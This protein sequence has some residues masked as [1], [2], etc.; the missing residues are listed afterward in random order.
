MKRRA[1]IALVGGVAAAWPFAAQG[2]RAG[3]RR[4]GVL[5][6]VN[7]E[8]A[9]PWVAGV[10]AALQ[11]LGWA[12]GSTLQ[13]DFRFGGG[14]S[15]QVRR[16][17]DELLGMKPDVILTQGVV[18]AAALQQT[19]TSTPVVFAQVQDPI[20][21]GFVT[22]LSRP[23]GNLTGFTD[24]EYSIAG[25]WLQLLHEAAPDA[26][27]V[28]VVINPD[29]RARWDGYFKVI[30]ALAPS[31]GILP[32]RAGVH[33][34]AEIERAIAA[35]AGEPNGGLLVLPDATTGAN[36]RLIVDLAARHRLPAIY[37]NVLF[38]RRG[39]LLAYSS[40]VIEQYRGAASYVDRLLRG[41]KVGD[42]PVH[43]SERFELAINL[44][45]AKALGLTLPQTMLV[46]AD[47]VIE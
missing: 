30:D 16:Y 17:A 39:G 22:S 28:L 12:E 19:R 45:T 29:N 41:A 15:E 44:K 3:M 5:F 40:S 2:Q 6:V 24:F 13:I 32:L 20:G 42:L 43:A 38:A 11:S 37:A 23:E 27:R 36:S 4:L 33:D 35:F 31:L 7:E 46:A 34:A 14:N 25:K 10:R 26:R 1:F 18:G 47:E 21:G 9:A 8:F